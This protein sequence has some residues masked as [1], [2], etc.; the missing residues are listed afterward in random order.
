MRYP[1]AHPSAAQELVERQREE[2]RQRHANANGHIGAT[3]NAK[4]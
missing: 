3:T 4:T 1:S 2:D